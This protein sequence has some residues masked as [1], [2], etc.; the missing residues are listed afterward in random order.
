LHNR[1]DELGV[2][3][4]FMTIPGGGHGKFNKETNT[5]LNTAIMKFL[6]SID[7]LKTE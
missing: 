4:E 3:N 1:L 5:S 2:K 7:A 6:M